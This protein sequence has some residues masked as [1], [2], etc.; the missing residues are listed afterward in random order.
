MSELYRDDFVNSIQENRVLEK[1]PRGK[2]NSVVRN[3]HLN[4]SVRHLS[5]IK[6]STATNLIVCIKDFKTK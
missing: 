2:F 6:V 1:K 3:G 5:K 4:A